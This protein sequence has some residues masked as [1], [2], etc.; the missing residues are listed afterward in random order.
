MQQFLGTVLLRDEIISLLKKNGLVEPCYSKLLDYVI[1]LFQTQGLGSDYYGYHNVEHELEVTYVTLLAA[2][3]YSLLG[4]FTKDDL[5]YLYVTALLHDFDPEKN[6]DKPHEEGVIRFIKGDKKVQLLLKEAGIEIDI[7]IALVLR[8]TFPWAGELKEKAMQQIEE[9]LSLPNTFKDS[10]DEKEHYKKL[11]WFL[12][13]ADR[14]SGYALGDFSKAMELAKKNAHALG[15]HPY[16]IV[17]RSVS[18]FEDLLNN[19]SEMCEEVLRS[20]P[21]TMRK[22]FMD[23]VLSFMRLRQREIEIKASLVYDNVKLVPTI[24]SGRRRLDDNFIDTLFAIYQELPTPLQFNKNNFRESIKDPSTVVNTLR[25]G[26]E[27]GEI[28]GFAKGGPLENYELQQKIK[29]KNYG[30]FNTVFQEPLSL[31]MGYWGQKG[32]RE[33]RLLFTMLAQ[34]KGYKYLTSFALREVIQKR[35]ERN[36]KIEF[37]QKFDP[38]RWDYYRLKLT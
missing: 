9:S 13:V 3:W 34:A 27:N 29:D 8:T 15:W 14:I 22:A 33:M 4:Y 31:K 35:I 28:I 21:K 19:E 24:D 2:Q 18:F 12:S 6:V 38:E 20:L 11:G 23:N 1:E 26:N 16:F 10:P 7:I 37:V 36:E 25:L 32:G 5:K 30:L 17:R